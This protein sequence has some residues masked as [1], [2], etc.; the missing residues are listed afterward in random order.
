MARIARAGKGMRQRYGVRDPA[1]EADRLVA[2]R[3]EHGG[4]LLQADKDA[5]KSD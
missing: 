1:G 4:A 3:D 2:A 5:I